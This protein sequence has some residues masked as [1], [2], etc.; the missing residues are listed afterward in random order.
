LFVL[1]LLVLALAIGLWASALNV[2]YRDVQYA[3][4]FGLQVLLFASPVAY[5]AT[6]VPHGPW[7]I[8]YGLNPLVGVIQGFRW[9]LFGAA[10]P[11]QLVWLSVVVTL[12]VLMGGLL[13]FK[14]MEDRFADV[15]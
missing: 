2:Q 13:F 15:V 7:R 12:V 10:P 5:S 14:R 6:L 3:I 4:P 1:Q 8:L 11:G 9:A